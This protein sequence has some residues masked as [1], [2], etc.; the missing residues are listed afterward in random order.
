MVAIL[1]AAF[2]LPLERKS[3]NAQQLTHD[4]IISTC[5]PIN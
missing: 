5:L 2:L 1:L 4:N 3:L